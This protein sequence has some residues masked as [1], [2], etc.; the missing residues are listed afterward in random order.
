[1]WIEII[2]IKLVIAVNE[3][4][5]GTSPFDSD[6]NMLEVAPP[7]TAAIIITPTAN[8]GGKFGKIKIIIMKATTGK[9]IICEVKPIKTSLGW[10]IILVKSVIFNPKPKENIIKAI[11]MLNKSVVKSIINNTTRFF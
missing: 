8:S 2:Q 6:V 9:N 7:G 11:A 5:R 4:D 10:V 1:M 3:I